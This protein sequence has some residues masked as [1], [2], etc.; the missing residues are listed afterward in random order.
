MDFRTVHD[1]GPGLAEGGNIRSFPSGESQVM[2]E[3]LP[4]RPK[5]V[6]SMRNLA[7]QAQSTQQDM[8]VSLPPPNKAEAINLVKLYNSIKQK[9]PPGGNNIIQM[10]SANSDDGSAEIASNLAW[11]AS[12]ILG[13]TVLFIDATGGHSKLLIIPSSLQ[14]PKTLND[15]A[16]GRVPT[17]DAIAHCVG[18]SLSLTQLQQTTVF[19][20][21]DLT[22]SRLKYLFDELRPMFD[23]IIIAP[24]ATL[25]EP[26]LC[27]SEQ[28][29]GW[30]RACRPRRKV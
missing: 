14:S 1:N 22:T 5:H 6:A 19:G 29:R 13:N 21:E 28:L 27:H 20:E 18:Q 3:H 17:E 4:D 15:V 30:F 9:L 24:T 8:I 11:V 26:T 16:L 25:E 23:V 10:V 2:V 7:T 12:S